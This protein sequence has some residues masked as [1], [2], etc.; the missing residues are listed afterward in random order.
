MGGVNL[1]E[2]S[3]FCYTIQGVKTVA[4]LLFE[5]VLDDGFGRLVSERMRC[6]GESAIGENHVGVPIAHRIDVEEFQA[7]LRGGFKEGLVSD[8]LDGKVGLQRLLHA[9]LDTEAVL[10]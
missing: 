1:L 4:G 2:S 10:D 9:V 7:T 3:L 6:I 5:P 8:C